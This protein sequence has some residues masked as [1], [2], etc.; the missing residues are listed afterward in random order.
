[1]LEGRS[2]FLNHQVFSICYSAVWP[3]HCNAL[4]A[5]VSVWLPVWLLVCP[6]EGSPGTAKPS[7]PPPV[8]HGLGAHGLSL[9]PQRWGITW[10]ELWG[11]LVLCPHFPALFSGEVHPPACLS[12]WGR[13]FWC[14]YWIR[15]S[16]GLWN[17]GVF[18]V[19]S[20]L[21]TKLEQ[22]QE[23]QVHQGS[24]WD[25]WRYLELDWWP[26]LAVVPGSSEINLAKSH[27]W[28]PSP[29]TTT[30]EGQRVS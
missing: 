21:L 23:T 29:I 5:K 13:G 1:M 17:W 18:Q 7:S 6:D 8:Q 27:P 20:K 19:K 2:L 3:M 25:W 28:K 4:Q 26:I 10:T 30:G 24:Q 22:L 11:P 12:T 15:L 9:D 14:P 16:A